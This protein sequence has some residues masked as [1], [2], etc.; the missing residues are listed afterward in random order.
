MTL[1]ELEE[2]GNKPCLLLTAGL[3]GSGKSTLAQGLADR[4]SFC[5][6]RSDV[7]RK[8]LAGLSSAEP[9]PSPLREELY[10]RE[11]ME[12]TYAECLRRAE[13]LLF[14]GKRVI[15]DATFREEQQRRNFLEAA[16]V[17]GV[18]AYLLLCRAEPETVRQRLA[19]RQGDASDADWSVYQSLAET[20]EEIGATT[21]S[22]CHVI[23]TDGAPE[24][25]L[26]RALEVLRQCGL[27]G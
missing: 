1:G 12:R 22:F 10:T 25:A 11:G 21:R 3:P 6:I 14:E 27:Q 18:P 26:S 16:V 5:V 19:K 7:V 17:W 2:P 24:E 4:A 13:Q 20:W 8:K 15:V 23:A 9:S